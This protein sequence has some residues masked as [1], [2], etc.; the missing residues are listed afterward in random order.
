M[1]LEIC[2][3][4][5][6]REDTIEAVLNYGHT[7]IPVLIGP[8]QVLMAILPMILLSLGGL[9]VAAISAK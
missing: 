9:I 5:E 4:K 8:L 2:Q 3:A 7:V 1:L 6:P